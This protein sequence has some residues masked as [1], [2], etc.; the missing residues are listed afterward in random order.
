MTIYANVS[1]LFSLKK[2]QPEHIWLQAISEEQWNN[3]L[4]EKDDTSMNAEYTHW[5]NQS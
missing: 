4:N 1:E 3:K 5:E 2:T